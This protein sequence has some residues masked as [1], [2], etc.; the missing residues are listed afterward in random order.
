MNYAAAQDDVA[1]KVD[2]LRGVIDAIDDEIIAALIRRFHVSR[3]IQATRMA[4]GLPRIQHAREHRVIQRYADALGPIGT[5]LALEVLSLSRGN[6][7]R[8]GLDAVALRPR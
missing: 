8:L 7:T 1:R 3:E 4:A 2:E 5:E 6:P